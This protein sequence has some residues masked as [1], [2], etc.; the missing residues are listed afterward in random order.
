MMIAGR[1]ES[2]E[3]MTQDG[4]SCASEPGYTG[5]LDELHPG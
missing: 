4:E 3:A 1:E 2:D 5:P